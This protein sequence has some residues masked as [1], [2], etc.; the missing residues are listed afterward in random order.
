[1]KIKLFLAS[2]FLLFLDINLNAVCPREFHIEGEFN[3]CEYGGEYTYTINY[4]KVFKGMMWEV[5]GG[6]I[7]AID[8]KALYDEYGAPT[9]D[10]IRFSTI[11]AAWDQSGQTTADIKFLNGSVPGGISSYHTFTDAPITIGVFRLDSWFK[12]Y[13]KPENKTFS[14]TIRWTSSGYKHIKSGGHW[15]GA[16][17]NFCAYREE[18][19]SVT[20]KPSL[21]NINQISSNKTS[22][23][24]CLDRNYTFQTNWAPDATYYW[25]I[26]DGV[27]IQSWGQGVHVV[28]FSKPG[29]KNIKVTIVG[30]CGQVIVR[31]Y[32]LNVQSVFPGF[33]ANNGQNIQNE[34]VM[35]G[36]NGNFSLSLPYLDN[37]AIYRWEFLDEIS[38]PSV[39]LSYDPIKKVYFFQGTNKLSFSGVSPYYN[40]KDLKG[41]VTITNICGGPFVYDFTIKSLQIHSLPLII[42]SCD[43]TVNIAATVPQ[44]ATSFNWWVSGGGSLTSQSLTGA[45]FV[46]PS[47]GSYSISMQVQYANGCSSIRTVSVYISSSYSTPGGTGWMSGVL[48]DQIV[49]SSTN[50]AIDDANN[51]Y[52]GGRDGKIYYYYYEPGVSKWVLRSIPNVKDVLNVPNQYKAIAYSNFTIDKRIYYSSYDIGSNLNVLKYTDLNGLGN[53]FVVGSENA[54]GNICVDCAN[55]NMFFIKQFGNNLTLQ[56]YSENNSTS[57][58]FNNISG[59]SS[60]EIVFFDNKIF[61][62]KNNA[63][64]YS[65]YGVGEVQISPNDV[66]VKSNIGFDDFLNI[67]YISNDLRVKK[68]NHMDIVSNIVASKSISN[69]NLCEGEFTVNQ[70]TGVVY[71]KGLDKNIYQVYENSSTQQYVVKRATLSYLDFVSGKMIY[72]APHLFYISTAI[73]NNNPVKI[74]DQVWNLFYLDGCTPNTLRT[75]SGN[76]EIL[77]RIFEVDEQ[78]IALQVLTVYPNPSKDLINTNLLFRNFKIVDLMGKDVL[79]GGFDLLTNQIDISSL[80][81]GVYLLVIVSDDQS[82]LTTKFIKG[83]VSKID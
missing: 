35:P 5:I 34:V 64:Y 66:Y 43:N 42:E 47:A 70:A 1:M 26:P 16:T 7:T 67:Y 33:L 41:S 45:T 27:G 56:M 81:S 68:I 76:R 55:N 29:T 50:L 12:D 38:Y 4:D 39:P 46:A 40:I 77:D 72:K 60:G 6:Y 17:A 37:F 54:I 61:Y 19:R 74:A 28:G 83:D 21:G 52:F 24:N 58:S 36:C 62:I 49:A 63:L 25:E 9:R 73:T 65:S 75:S 32:T 79:D 23:T 8:G 30:N 82:V 13:I 3:V 48:S 11:N 22:N 44:G 51:I 69:P 59:L 31:T 80:V 10:L 2:V 53:Q 18:A 71:F 20:F 78:V 15:L 57:G 14:V